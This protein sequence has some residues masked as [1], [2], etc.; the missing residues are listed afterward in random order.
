MH[1]VGDLGGQRQRARALDA[2]QDRQ[3]QGSSTTQLVALLESHA[4]CLILLD[5]VLQYLAKALVVPT[6]DGNLAATS[7]T[8]IKELTSA[9]ANTP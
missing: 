8:F 3:L 2:E 4:P 1:A 9:V 6:H 7:L 5:E